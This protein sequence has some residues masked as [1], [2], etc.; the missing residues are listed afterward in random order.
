MTP[1][2]TNPNLYT[3]AQL[4]KAVG[5]SKR[6]FLAS[7]QGTAQRGIVV[8]SGNPAPAWAMADLPERYSQEI[9][10]T[11]SATGNRDAHS[12]I[13]TA[14]EPW[15]LK[16]PISQRVIAL[17][18]IAAEAIDKAAKLRRALARVI[19]LRNNPAI[20]SR[21]LESIGL[22]DYRRE[23]GYAITD[24]SFRALL[25]RT[26]ERDNFAENW[27]RL[28]IYLDGNPQRKASA[29]ATPAAS[30]AAF[31]ELHDLMAT[32]T[33]AADPSSRER[34]ALWLEA[35]KLLAA[36]SRA[37]ADEKRTRINLI[38]FL[39]QA[40]PWIAK[41]K[42]A[43][44]VSF[45]FKC[46]RWQENEKREDALKDGR[47]ARRGVPT[48]P[49][50]EENHKDATIACALFATGGRVSQANREVMAM[51]V[52]LDIEPGVAALLLPD[53]AASKSYVNRRLREAVRHEVRMLAP[54]NIGQRALDTARASL[55][56]HYI[57]VPSGYCYS[58]D[59]VT[60]PVYWHVPDGEGWFKLVRGQCLVTI[61]ARTLRILG[62]SLQ[63]DRN[64]SSPVI[65][66]NFTRV[67]S[68]WGVP[69]YLYLER[70]IWKNSKLITGGPKAATNHADY[71]FMPF[72]W[73]ETERGFGDL[74]VTFKHAIRARTKVV[75]TVMRLIQA[76]MEREPGYCGRDERRDLPADTKR[77]MDD[78]KFHRTH[79]SKYFYDFNQWEARL[80]EIFAVYNAT[81]QEGEMLDGMSPDEAQEKLQSPDAAKRP[82][83]FD[84][85]CRHLLAHYRVV[86]EVG[87]D[88][89]TITIGKKKWIYRSKDLSLDKFKRMIGWFNPDE[90]SALAVTD[91][92]MK[93]PYSVPLSNPVGAIDPDPEIF[94][95][96]LARVEEYE[97]YGKARYKV[98]K[99]K[100]A[101]L[102]RRMVPNRL[103]VET[104]QQMRQQREVIQVQQKQVETRKKRVHSR[105]KELGLP[106]R[107]VNT[108]AEADEGTALMLEAKRAHERRQ[109][110]NITPD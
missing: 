106:S 29:P 40:A 66:T 17:T 18:E 107:I 34:E 84:N 51:A 65:H 110:S 14:A 52:E 8:V 101:P 38:N 22:E 20:A 97:A 5:I 72:S 24:R 96:E 76:Y 56:R 49:P 61:D 86:K 1:E 47:E 67:F 99:A 62:F 57:N 88:G 103:T 64:Y 44:R 93:N 102:F 12:F 95:Q 94:A 92:N 3:A 70:G 15:Q 83:L 71:E 21:E 98:L 100:Y 104:G 16:D 10:K 69:K 109:Q 23:F 90:P 6:T 53:D 45:Q 80:V 2:S 46:D 19:E 41:S 48:A 28:E 58:S 9:Q 25:K 78:V 39:W 35:V 89:F 81:V 36:Q 77:Q 7:M 31:H 59:D 27:N 32:F 55:K 79:P 30:A 13:T 82:L 108:S 68:D 91:L 4:A 54:Y 42:N 105:V 63:P 73:A 75:E 74:G 33:N 60:L 43:L 37:G 50:I 11:L 26:V 87:K 85:S